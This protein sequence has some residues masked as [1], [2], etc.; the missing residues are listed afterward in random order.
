MQY[1]GE[2]NVALADLIKDELADLAWPDLAEVNIVLDAYAG[3]KRKTEVPVRLSNVT[4]VTAVKLM[5]PVADLYPV[6]VDIVSKPPSRSVSLIR[7]VI[8][9]T[10]HFAARSRN[11]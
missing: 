3:G 7:Q 11:A 4:L 1:P 5:A 6:T 9:Q 8:E 2:V 10:I